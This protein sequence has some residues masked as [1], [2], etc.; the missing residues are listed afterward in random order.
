MR[1]F[2]LKRNYLAYFETPDDALPLGVIH[3]N[4]CTIGD[5][6]EKKHCFVLNKPGRTFWLQTNSNDEKEQWMTCIKECIVEATELLISP[7]EHPVSLTSNDNNNS[8]GKKNSKSTDKMGSKKRRPPERTE[9]HYFPVMSNKRTKEGFLSK[10][11]Q[12]FQNWKLRWFI[13][14]EGRLE[15]FKSAS[16]DKPLGVLV[17]S[18]GT[19]V[20]IGGNER[21]ALGIQ[22]KTPAR[23][24]F[25]QAK[26]RQERDLWEKAI[27]SEIMQKSWQPNLTTR[28]SHNG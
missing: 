14:Q 16:D 28:I 10:K 21:K 13:L 5:S 24:L 22:V 19:T 23:T 27:T 2:V 6:N 26:T 17:L 4:Q 3:L 20:M 9:S 12:N 8:V 25:L 15:Y 1:L 11:G 18:P 7:K